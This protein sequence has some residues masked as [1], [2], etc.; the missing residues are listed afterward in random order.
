MTQSQSESV[1]LRVISWLRAVTGDVEMTSTV[2]KR[3]TKQ[4]HL[5]SRDINTLLMA[6]LISSKCTLLGI[7]SCPE[8]Y[9]IR[10]HILDGIKVNR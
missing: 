7:Y 10:R 1:L 9:N 5:K 6:A 8:I 2:S 4:I 3:T